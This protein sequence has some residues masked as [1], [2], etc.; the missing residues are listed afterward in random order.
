MVALGIA[1]DKMLALEGQPNANIGTPQQAKLDQLS[2][3]LASVLQQRGLGTGTVT[4]TE[5]T[6]ELKDT[7]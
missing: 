2:T 5:R 1:T 6:V 7:P 4:L 3:A